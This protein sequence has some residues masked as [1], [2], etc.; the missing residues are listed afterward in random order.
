MGV[1]FYLAFEDGSGGWTEDVNGKC[2][3]RAADELERVL[4]R[5]R[6]PS[7]YSFCSETRE[8]AIVEAGGDPDDPSSFDE[9]AIASPTWHTPDRG[10]SVVRCLLDYMRG[11]TKRIDNPECVQQDLKVFEKQLVA[12]AAHGTRWHL[13]IY[14]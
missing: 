9:A 10:L 3:A 14:S 5:A 2:I 7:I 12:A 6:Q 13:V 8:Q 1:A 4:K 11:K